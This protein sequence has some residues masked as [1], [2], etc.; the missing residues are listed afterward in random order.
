M[1]FRKTNDV[2]YFKISDTSKI[3]ENTICYLH[4]TKIALAFSLNK[5]RQLKKAFACLKG[6]DFCLGILYQI[7][8]KIK[9]V[10]IGE[11][12]QDWNHGY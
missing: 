6:S 2:E 5:T 12:L 3:S 4:K 11:D 7:N 8:E 1:K 10:F 9:D